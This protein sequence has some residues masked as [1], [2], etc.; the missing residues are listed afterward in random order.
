MTEARFWTFVFILTALAVGLIF[1]LPALA[2]VLRYRNL[3]EEAQG[4]EKEGKGWR[5]SL[6]DIRLDPETRRRIRRRYREQMRKWCP[7]LEHSRAPP[8][9][10]GLMVM[11]TELWEKRGSKRRGG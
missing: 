10:K 6:A 3:P 9:V 4:G 1:G 8:A 11:I 5:V 7:P 2:D